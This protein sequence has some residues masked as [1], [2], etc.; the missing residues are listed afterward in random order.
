VGK[1]YD[2]LKNMFDKGRY[3]IA[4][5]LRG[6]PD[7][8]YLA[9]EYQSQSMDEKQTSYLEQVQDRIEVPQQQQQKEMMP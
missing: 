9:P 7:T 3:E 4:Q 1:S 6:L 5:A 8:G 2:D